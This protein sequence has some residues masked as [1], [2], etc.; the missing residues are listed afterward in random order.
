[1]TDT[2]TNQTNAPGSAVFALPLPGTDPGNTTGTAGSITLGTS[3]YGSIGTVGDAD[4]YA[5]NLVAGVTYEFRL[6]GVGSTPL[7]DTL[8]TLRD[9]AGGLITS[10]D[11]GSGAFGY[12]SVLT[13]TA[14]TTGTHYL[15]AED[16]G[17]NNIGDFL[18][19]AVVQNPAGTVL[20]ADEVSWQLTNNFRRFFDFGNQGANVSSTAYDV[21]GVRQITYN[22]D[23]LDAT[24]ILLSTNALQMWTDVTGIVFVDVAGA[25]E[26]T[27]DDS[28]AGNNAYNSNTVDPNGVITASNLMLTTGWIA[29]FGNT[30]NSY[31]FETYIHELGHSLGLGHGGNYNGSAVY[32]TDNF[33]VNDSQHLSIMSYMQSRNDEFSSGSFGYN[34]FVNAEFRW[35]LTPMIADIIAMSNLYGLSTTTRTGANVYG[36]NSN[37]GNAVLDA[38][39]TLN[40]PVARNFVA[41][42]VFDNGGIDRIDMSGFAGNQRINLAEGSTSDVLGGTLNM[43]IAYGTQIENATGG[44][45]NDDIR[46]NDLGNTLIGNAGEDILRGLNGAD[47]LDGG[48]DGAQDLLLGGTGD[49]T[50]TVN[51]VEDIV[52]ELAGQGIDTVQAF[53]NYTLGFAVENLVMI[54]GTSGY[55]NELDNT[56]SGNGSDNTLR[57]RDGDD[58]LNGNNGVDTLV[59]GEG[60]DVLNGGDGLDTA[61][62]TGSTGGIIASLA[63]SAGNTGDAAGDTYISV[64]NLTGTNFADILAGLAGGVANVLRGGGGNDTLKGYSGNDELNGGADNDILI[65]GIGADTLIGG[66]GID[67][68]S[69]ED[70]AA[71]VTASMANPGANAGDALGDTYDTIEGLIGSNHNDILNGGNGIE[72]LVGG[73]GNDSLK[74]YLG[75]DVMTGGSGQDTFY[76]VSALSAS[77]FD[78][79]TDFNVADDTISLE[80]AIF[81]A[82]ATG[83]LAAVAFRSN[84]TGQAQD[85]DDR[86]IYNS[87]NGYLYYDS[88]GTGAAG[89]VY[90]ADLASGLAMTAGDFVV[91]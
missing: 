63:N 44:S 43:G 47:A 38:L 81:T 88:D 87:T 36:Y 18:L 17:N 46:G 55:G 2:P 72:T 1:M 29:N 89:R 4:W 76:F 86:I 73:A 51:E 15:D 91:T 62:Y 68:A 41:F 65:G 57:G 32:G 56:I 12:N 21:S 69:Y 37:T 23:G 24:G 27:L 19:T 60:A 7:A 74:S 67:M 30:F 39:T 5:V 83:N 50:Y 22:N 25:A 59:G 13:F 26:I 66:S 70:A 58:T 78:Q 82:L 90:F 79:I 54:A 85:A 28:E 61:Y 3:V 49:D 6:L 45:G 31:S 8:L 77:N 53:L 80:N 20:T 84:T 14:A 35:V 52:I 34:D 33:Y 64:E 9:S 71:G 11:D 42:T 48:L 16:L 75:N 40:D 10:N